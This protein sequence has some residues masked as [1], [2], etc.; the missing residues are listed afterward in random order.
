M[1][2]VS[3]FPASRLTY[4]LAG[5]LALTIATIMVGQYW[6]RLP[7]EIPGS[8]ADALN[9]VLGLALCLA[10]FAVSVLARSQLRSNR[11]LA[12]ISVLFLAL[13]IVEYIAEAGPFDVAIALLWLAPAL[14]LAL[15]PLVSG[16]FGA[17]RQF[18]AVA[19]V[20]QLAETL[21]SVLAVAYYRGTGEPPVFQWIEGASDLL[22]RAFL[23]LGFVETLS[24][25]TRSTPLADAPAGDQPSSHRRA[26]GR[27]HAAL[28]LYK[29]SGGG[30]QR[31]SVTLA[32]GLAAR[33]YDVDFVV[34]NDQ[35]TS[36]EMLGPGVRFLALNS[37]KWG[38]LHATLYQ[39]VPFRWARVYIGA[40]A[41]ARYMRL[42]KPELVVAGSNRVLLT[43]VVAWRM[44]GRTMP[45]LL[46]ATNFPSGNLNLWAPLR[47]IVDLYLRA[48]S[49]L[50]YRHATATIAVA[51][52]VAD[53][54][55]R[56]SGVS[57]ERIATVFEPVLDETIAERSTEALDH[58]WLAKGGPPVLL[59]VGRLR[60]Q[61]D[62]PT[63]IAAFALARKKRPMRLVLLGEGSQRPRLQKMIA[64]HGLEN[65]VC[66]FG[67][68]ENPFAWMARASLF[69]MSSA[70]E[71]LPAVLIEALA[72]GCPV[73]S[74][75]CPSGP[76]EILDKGK[77]GR[78]VPC[79]DPQSLAQ[80]ILDTLDAPVDRQLLIERAKAFTAQ[81]SVDGYIAI[82]NRVLPA[83]RPALMSTG[84]LSPGFPDPSQPV[85]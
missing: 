45:L 13:S 53:E 52:G 43:S 47:P 62:F 58:P 82:F 65:D 33:G 17:A 32:N 41:L 71:G 29:L 50:V 57:R 70:W 11:L 76:W 25:V 63:L 27:P 42:E 77:Y 49:H 74:T 69:V 78:L 79:R 6:L 44:A 1:I 24:R 8:P 2:A 60:M 72:C 66:L 85:G 35:S 23:L 36:R 54:V 31:R 28:F 68:S 59:G 56:L 7:L 61:K 80:A 30:A 48:L 83:R 18:F 14:V 26:T 21:R 84:Q 64:S 3:K 20:L 19:T 15:T 12:G 55:A 46:R 4:G 10:G 75:N 39:L 22:V 73:V 81:A 34:I 37:P 38:R 9:L 40:I 51:D 16:D 5:I 67:Y